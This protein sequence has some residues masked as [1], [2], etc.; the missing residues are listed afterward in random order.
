[1][2]IKVGIPVSLTGQFSLQGRQTLAGLCAWAADVNRSGGL[3]VGRRKS[4]VEIVWYDDAS[5]RDNTRAITGRLI[6]DDRVDLLIGPYSAVLANAAAEVV[7][8]RGKLLWNQG[9]ASPLVYRRGNLWV[10][11]ILTPAD[12]YLAGL[13]SAVREVCPAASTYAIALAATGAFPRDVT[14]GVERTAAALGF[15]KVLSL[16]FDAE[17]DDFRETVSEV[18]EAAPDVLVVAGRF[19]N[20]LNLAELLVESDPH[21]GAVAVVAAGVDAFRERLG[22]MAENFIGPSQWEP[23]AGY[24]VDFGPTVAEV[25]D[26]LRRV[27]HPVIDYP[28]AQAYAVGVVIQRCVEE[29]SSLDDA[30]L[31]KAAVSLDFTTFYGRFRIDAETGRPIGKPALLVQWQQ[32]RKVMVW[33]PE[34]RV[35]KLAYPWRRLISV[36]SGRE[37]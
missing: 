3:A 21:I 2:T 20:D 10:V 16:Q 5:R 35:E 34:R 19:Q 26:S 11:G 28:M 22:G 31:R 30:A 4:P 27:G 24:V 13:L 17:G 36:P 32:G 14:A 18:R 7:Q 29:C 12:E 37:K 23:D 9:G 25:Q 1:M 8:A 33:P 15:R 6:A